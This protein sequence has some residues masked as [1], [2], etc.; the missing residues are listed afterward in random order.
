MGSL[1][2]AAVKTIAKQ[3]LKALNAIHTKLRMSHG[4]VCPSQILLEKN[5]DVK[6]I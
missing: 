6:V 5:G 2:E 3:I 1:P 4:V